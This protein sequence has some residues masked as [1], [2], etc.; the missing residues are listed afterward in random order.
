MLVFLMPAEVSSNFMMPLLPEL[1][2]SLFNT[3]EEP[4]RKGT[5]AFQPA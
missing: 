5:A 4:L 3:E 2:L 1:M